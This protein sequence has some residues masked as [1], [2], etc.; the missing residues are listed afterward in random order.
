MKLTKDDFYEHVENKQN[1]YTLELL[2]LSEYQMLEMV[3]ASKLEE[4]VKEYEHEIKIFT[5]SNG[6]MV[7]N[8]LR[9]FMDKLHTIHSMENVEN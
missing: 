4:L 6:R 2:D 3:S 8:E 9:E 1:A 5:D 7:T